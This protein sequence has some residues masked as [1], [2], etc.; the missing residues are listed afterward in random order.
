MNNIY[1]YWAIFA[2]GVLIFAYIV[3]NKNKKHTSN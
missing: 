2:T 1:L 3:T